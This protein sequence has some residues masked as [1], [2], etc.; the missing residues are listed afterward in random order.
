MRNAIVILK[1]SDKIL[2]GAVPDML[3][4]NVD[5]AVLMPISF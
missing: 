1:H 4:K 3:D 2:F 5:V